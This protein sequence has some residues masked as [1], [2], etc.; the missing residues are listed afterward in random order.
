MCPGFASQHVLATWSACIRQAGLPSV[1]N[2][3][4][5]YN[6]YSSI[7]AMY[8]VVE[9]H[10]RWYP[11]QPEQTRFLPKYFAVK[12]VADIV[13]TVAWK[14]LD[15]TD[16]M[17]KVLRYMVTALSNAGHNVLYKIHRYSLKDEEL[18]YKLEV[19]R[20]SVEEIN[21]SMIFQEEL[22]SVKDVLRAGKIWEP[23]TQAVELDKGGDEEGRKWLERLKALLP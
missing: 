5:F 13:N 18:E 6:L 11:L 22:V 4:Q 10:E 8:E 2:A 1:Q 3:L 15:T 14:V 12:P 23:T 17:D 16:V 19:I 7:K 20:G 9:N 21:D